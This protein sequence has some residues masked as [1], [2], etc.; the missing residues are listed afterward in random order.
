MRRRA[1]PQRMSRSEASKRSRPNASSTW[2][3]MSVPA[4]MVGARSGCSPG[5]AR[6]SSSGSAARV[7][8]ISAEPRAAHDVALHPRRVV[9]LELRRRSRR[10]R[11]PCRPPRRRPHALAH[12][13]RHRRLEHRAH[14]ARERVDALAARAGRR[15]GG[16]RCGARRPAWVETWKSISPR[17]PVTSS[18]EPPPMSTT[19]SG[20][21]SPRSRAAVAPR[22]VS[23]ASSSPLS[24]RASRP[25]RSR[26][27]AVNSAPLSASRTADGEHG[28]A[29]L[30]AVALDRSAVLRRARRARAPARLA[31]P[32]GRV[33]AL[34]E[35]RDDRAAVE[36]RPRRRRTSA[37]S[38]RV[39]FV[40]MSTTATRTAQTG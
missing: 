15:A 5:T 39:E 23:R 33:H 12:L 40:P 26:T 8:E 6:R 31:E 18:V 30:A 14:V 37:T 1:A 29:P 2:A 17:A 16:A 9:G 28:E 7:A 13:G 22:N 20:V 24:V 38:R 19:S 11:S 35:A 10:P 27:A 25:K 34:A 4:T 32:A 3:R 21:A 36:L